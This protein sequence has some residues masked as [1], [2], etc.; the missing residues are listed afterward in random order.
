MRNLC[1]MKWPR[2]TLK[3]LPCFW[4]IKPLTKKPA[5]DILKNL[6]YFE[7][8]GQDI[9]SSINLIF[10]KSVSK[11]I[12]YVLEIKSCHFWENSIHVCVKPMCLSGSKVIIIHILFYHNFTTLFTTPFLLLKT[13]FYMFRVEGVL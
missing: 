6:T 2:E 5:R 11:K 10:M 9:S 3:N 7:A 12:G 4:N 1:M 8:F 13:K